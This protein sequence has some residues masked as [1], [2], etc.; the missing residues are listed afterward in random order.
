MDFW[1]KAAQLIL[2][3]SILVILHE[4]GHFIPARLFKI[5]V[6]KFYLFFD[7]GFSLFKFKKGDTEY[8]I[9]WLP[10]GGYVKIAGM[11][12]ESMDTDHLSKPAEDWEFRSKPAWQRLIV[13]SGGVVVNFIL[14]IVLY[15]MLLFVW[16]EDYIANDDLTHGMTVHEE[17]EQYGF[18]DGDKILKVDGEALLSVL[19]VNKH[20][21]LRGARVLEVEHENGNVETIVLPENTD[22]MM[23]Q[24]DIQM[25]FMPR[26]RSAIAIVVD[27]LPA[28]KAG[29]KQGD[30]IVAINDTP[31]NYWSD[32]RKNLK[33]KK[34]EEV[35]IKVKRGAQIELL[36]IQPDSLGRIGVLPTDVLDKFQVHNKNYTL[37]E[38][39][40]GGVSQ[41]YWTLKDYIAQFKFVFTKKGSTAVGGFASV[42]RLFPAEW[43][44][45]AFWSITAFLSI[46]LAFLN[47]LPI[48]MLDGGHIVFLTYEM[49]AGRPPSEKFLMNAQMVGLV[50]VLGLFLYSNGLDILKVLGI[51]AE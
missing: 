41:A 18:R 27:S 1:I 30:E 15:A 31:I 11:I 8:G 16:G 4:L 51:I 21:F 46:M 25:P 6:E 47:L 44:W 10:L 13:M 33:D 24:K 12:D 7:A 49:I 37:M 29:L 45:D 19:D 38:S 36:T 22:Q 28:A 40:S 5:K 17:F 32:I 43:H 3:L 23:F 48:P 20:L 26:Y 2:S 42:G 50:I 14:A 34:N 35:A 9:G 39:L